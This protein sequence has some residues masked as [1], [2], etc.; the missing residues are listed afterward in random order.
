MG[1][2]GVRMNYSTGPSYAN[3]IAPRWL[4]DLSDF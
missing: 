1:E 3:L 4:T 2:W